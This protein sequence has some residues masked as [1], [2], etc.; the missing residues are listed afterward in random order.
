VEVEME[1]VEPSC[2]ILSL[3]VFI[4]LFCSNL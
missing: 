2:L 4:Q 1:G 3:T